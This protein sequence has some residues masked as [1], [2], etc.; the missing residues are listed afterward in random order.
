MKSRE[1]ILDKIRQIRFEKKNTKNPS[2]YVKLD[3]QLITLFW[4][5]SCSDDITIK[6][7]G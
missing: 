3:D 6:K 1:Q 2:K 5:L 4:V 7:Q